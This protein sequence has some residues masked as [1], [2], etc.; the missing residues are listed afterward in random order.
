MNAFEF[1]VP[2]VIE[3]V[4]HMMKHFCDEAK[5]IDIAE[6]DHD[7]SDLDKMKETMHSE[8]S[9][10]RTEIKEKFRRKVKAVTAVT[11]LLNSLR[12]ER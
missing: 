4:L 5:A 8:M 3:S 7:D 2:L 9:T 1:S 12:S 10:A 6:D 11:S